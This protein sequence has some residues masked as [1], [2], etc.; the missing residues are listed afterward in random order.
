MVGPGDGQRETVIRSMQTG[1][2]TAYGRTA[3]VDDP[4][5]IKAL[6]ESGFVPASLGG[7][8]RA[9]ARVCGGCGFH[10]YFKTCGRCGGACE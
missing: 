8:D 9:R 2:E 3:T 4:K 7:V 10:G 5:H 6:K 1:R